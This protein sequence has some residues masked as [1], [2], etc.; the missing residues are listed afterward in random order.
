MGRGRAEEFCC[1]NEVGRRFLSK[2]ALVEELPKSN[3]P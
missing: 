3:L 2:G 1:L